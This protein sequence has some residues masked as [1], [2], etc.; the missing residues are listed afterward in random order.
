MALDWYPWYV[1]DF[2]RDTL[3]LS[4]AQEG[5][6]RRLIDEYMLTRGPLPDD[7]V[8]LARILGT[9]LPDWLNVAQAVRPYFKSKGGQL[10]HSRCDQEIRAQDMRSGRRSERARKGALGKAFKAK[11]LAAPS[12]HMPATLHNIGVSLSSSESVTAQ[13]GASELAEIVRAKGWVK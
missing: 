13:K 4:L 9:G 6:Y 11:L 10:F 8:S 12:K 1:L 7:D 3:R 2:R 5:A